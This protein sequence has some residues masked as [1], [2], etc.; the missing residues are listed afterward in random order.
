M[1]MGVSVMAEFGFSF[2]LA[3]FLDLLV[4]AYV[5]C[6]MNDMKKVVGEK[7][8]LIAPE[9][10]LPDANN[11]IGRGIVYNGLLNC[12]EISSMRTLSYGGKISLK[13]KLGR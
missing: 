6:A 5:D 1:T 7:A 13:F 9:Q 10:Y 12:D 8:L 4:G 3:R 11:N 2:Q